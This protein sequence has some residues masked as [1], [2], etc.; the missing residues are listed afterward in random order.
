ML[1]DPR[2][3]VH[4]PRNFRIAAEPAGRIPGQARRPDQRDSGSNML[5][6]VLAQHRLIKRPAR[7]FR[8]RVGVRVN[9]PRQHQPSAGRRPA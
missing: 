9:Q 2:P 5:P 3:G 6:H 4:R 1:S 7:R 8:A